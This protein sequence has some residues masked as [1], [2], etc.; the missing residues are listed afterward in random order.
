MK[1]NSHPVYPKIL[2]VDD[3]QD[4]LIA[5]ERTLAHLPVEI[6]ST[7]SPETALSSLVNH[8]FILALLDIQMPEMDGYELAEL[9][10][11]NA[12]TE[13]IPIIF[14]TAINKLEKDIAKGYQSGCVDYIFKPFNAEQLVSK[15]KVFLKMHKHMLRAKKIEHD[16]KN[17]LDNVVDGYWNWEINSDQFYLNK[18]FKLSLGYTNDEIRN[19]ISAWQHLI[20]DEDKEKA[21]TFIKEIDHNASGNFEIRFT[22]KSGEILDYLCQFVTINDLSG[23]PSRVI[24]TYTNISSIKKIEKSLRLSNSELENFAYITS[25]DL[26]APLRGIENLLNWIARDESDHLSEKSKNYFEKANQQTKRM[27]DLIS[28]ILSYSR[29][30]T[31]EN[32]K[33]LIDLNKVVNEVIEDEYISSAATINIG[34]SLPTISSCETQMKQLFYNL[35]NNA[36]KHNDKENTTIDVKFEETNSQYIISVEDNGPGI[37]KQYHDKI[38]QLFQTL[39]PKSKT[40]S[41][42]VGLTIVKK[43][44]DLHGGEITIDSQSESGTRFNLCLPKVDQG[45]SYL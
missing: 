13:N 43:I 15:V 25:H 36:I 16:L 39:Q 5:I 40:N 9:M 27:N 20:F 33:T 10:S 17:I 8:T 45:K 31:A 41:T 37:D 18:K 6:I 26:R 34:H 4:N 42:G 35:F 1:M 19:S 23:L 32:I 7:T 11:N 21:L 3:I 22:H 24:G 28:G 44:I 30:T 2:V 14:L 29:L 12:Q 38:F